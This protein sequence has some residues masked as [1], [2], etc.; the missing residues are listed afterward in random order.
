MSYG[1]IRFNPDTTGVLFRERLLPGRGVIKRFRGWS[2]S[3]TIRMKFKFGSVM[4]YVAPPKKT[5]LFSRGKKIGWSWSRHEDDG[6][7]AYYTLETNDKGVILELWVWEQIAEVSHKTRRLSKKEERKTRRVRKPPSD[8][9]LFKEERTL[10]VSGDCKV[11]CN[12][13]ARGRVT[14]YLAKRSQPA[15]I[16]ILQPGEKSCQQGVYARDL[17]GIRS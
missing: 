10:Q 5:R 14:V 12:E 7:A 9:A 8:A 15:Y 13:E 3:D 6:D 4:V 16:D 1:G 2:D 17:V 11:K